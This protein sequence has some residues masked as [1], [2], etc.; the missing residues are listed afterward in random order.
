MK[1]MHQSLP[2]NP[3]RGGFLHNADLTPPPCSCRDL[4]GFR[5]F[6]RVWDM[7][8]S[9]RWESR[10]LEGLTVAGSAVVLTG[11]AAKAA[12]QAVLVAIRSRKAN[13]A[14]DSLAYTVLAHALGDAVSATG[15]ADVREP[16]DSQ[17]LWADEPTVS[18]P[19]AARRLGIG[20]RQMRRLAREKLE[21]R[22]RA[23]SWFVREQTLNDYMEDRN[24]AIN[25][26]GPRAG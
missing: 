5:D 9:G 7:S 13:G 16:V 18:V 21:G 4:Y 10:R 22:K 24:A 12:L 23:G 6:L 17:D 8:A 25:S 19:E 11:S 15:H 20:E 1:A 26:Q 14:G 3:G 2:R